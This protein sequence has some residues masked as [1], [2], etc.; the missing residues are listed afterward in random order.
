MSSPA[1]EPDGSRP[2]TFRAWTGIVFL[3]V[4]VL[5]S[6]YLLG[7]AVVRSDFA[8]MLLLAP[9]VLLALWVIYAA[10]A[11]S[12]LRVDADGVVMQNLLRRTAFGWSH[13]KDIDFRWQLEFALDDD[14]AVTS[15]GGPARSRPRR[16][17]AR[18]QDVEG[19]KTPSGVQELADLRQRWKT[20]SDTDQPIRRSWDR[21]ALGV[22]VLIVVWAVIAIVITR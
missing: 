2:R 15:M 18:E 16:Q 3:G 8:H 4:S 10:S 7:D 1:R 6:L 9:W 11:A 22:L 14:S 12:F 13:V 19:A 21:P 20:A 5:V 17:T